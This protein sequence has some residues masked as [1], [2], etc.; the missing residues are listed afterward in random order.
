MTPMRALI[1]TIAVSIAAIMVFNADTRADNAEGAPAQFVVG[2]GDTLWSI[3]VHVAPRTDPRRVI[4]V[5][6]ALNGLSNTE[7]YPG[8]RLLVPLADRR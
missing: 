6:M 3:A 2:K 8:Q 4:E 1:I 5:I 7:V